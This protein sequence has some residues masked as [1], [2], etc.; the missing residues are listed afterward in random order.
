MA[1]KTTTSDTTS[2]THTSIATRSSLA[3]GSGVPPPEKP[4]SSIVL[5][6]PQPGA[7]ISLGAAA[8]GEDETVKSLRR[9]EIRATKPYDPKREPNFNA[10]LAR[11]VF[12]MSVLKIPDNNRTSS[13]L[14]LFDTDS[15]EA[16]RHFC[17]TR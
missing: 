12:H 15:F 14:L 16:G 17:Y 1:E 5:M 3:N 10:W 9:M 6:P 4:S 2:P 13:L 11:V 7:P 8:E